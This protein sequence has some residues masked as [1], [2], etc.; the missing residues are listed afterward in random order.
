MSTVLVETITSPDPAIRNRSLRSLLEPMSTPQRLAECEALERFRRHRDNLYER[1]RACLFLYATHRFG[2]QEAPGITPA[3]AIPFDGYVDLLERRFEQAIGRFRAARE[4]DGA[5]AAIISALAEAYRHLAFQTLTDQVRRSVRSWRGNQWMFR[6]GHH[7]D[8]PVRVHP[9]L[10]R[11]EPGCILYPILTEQTPVRLDLS[12]SGWSDIFFLGM[13]HPEGARVLN[14]SVDLGVYGRD[15]HVRPPIETYVRVLEEP[16]LRLTSVDLEATKDVTALADLF[17]FGNDYLGLLKAGVIASGLIPP[18][19]EGS[20]QDLGAIL[21]QIVGPGLGLEVVTQVNDI[22]KGSRLAVSTNLLASLIALLM[23]AT[24]QTQR[25]EG[26]LEEYE[27]RLVASRAILGEWLGGSGGGWQ[28]SGGIWPGIKIIHGVVAAEGDPEFGV[29]RGCLLPQHQVFGPDRVSPQVRD[30]LAASMIV[31]HGGMAQDVGPILEMVTEKYLLRAGPEWEA[32]AELGRIFDG[33]VEALQ[34]GDVRGVASCTTRNWDGPLKTIIPQVTN[35][36]T[37]TLIRRAREQLGDD[38]WGF[39]MLG[40][41][42]GGGM[43]LFVAPHRQAAFRDELLDIMRHAKRDLD[44]ALPFAIDPVVYDFRINDYGSVASVRTGPAAIMPPRYYAVQVPALAHLPRA[45]VPLLRRADL[46]TFTSTG[47]DPAE[48]L[49]VLRVMVNHLFPAPGSAADAQA[50]AWQEEFRRIQRENGFDAVQ[51]E[52][53]RED[54]RRGRIGLARNRLAADTEIRDVEPGDVI[55]IQGGCADEAVRAGEDA[56][57][58]GEVAIVS[59]AAGVGSRWTRG[60]GVVKAVNPFVFI[61]GRHRSF[62]EIHLAKSRRASRRFGADMPHVFTT[63]FLTHQPIERHLAMHNRYGYAGPLSLSP[64]RSIATRLVPMVRDLR[65][66]WEELPQE[67]LD[68]Q[69][70]KV[71]DD[72]RAA[73]IAWARQR[74]EGS[75]YVD[76][77]PLQCFCPPGHWY[78]VPNLLRNG[79]LAQLLAARPNLKHLLVHNIDTLGADAD[80]GPLGV[81]V[82]SDNCLTFEVIGRRIDDRGGGLA[83]VNGRVR[84]LEGLAQPREAD[85]FRLR[86]YNSM[87]TWVNIDRLLALFGL[88]REALTGPEETIAERIRTAAAR[89]PTYVTIKEVKRRWGHGQE[90]VFPV[91]Q[92]EKLWSDMTSL[93]DVRCGFLVVPRR[94]GQQLKDVAQLDPWLNDGSLPY[95]RSL[96]DFD[97]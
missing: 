47:K 4:R 63:S 97:S 53:L 61:D 39:L 33:L 70:Q 32:R 69:K 37:E 51:H 17:N 66:L 38:F 62:L 11:R 79:V 9:R 91:S 89:L 43:A 40:G 72:V 52:Q 46:D 21:A 27:R 81:H 96:C 95:V 77:T 82:L 55:D 50:D 12:H 35:H 36:F 26:P 24:S 84:L 65:F 19:F 71:R 23:R 7:A 49:R 87:T 1:V 64:G 14:I 80:P 13:D 8:H 29:S 92:T 16:A 85:E 75:D 60:A 3:G 68:E 54:L 44:D 56:L 2:L 18:S 20:G 30:A 31:V 6:V 93:P 67:T 22:P 15:R 73:L 5:N 59:L 45:Q 76:N 10:R 28:D 83:R 86:Y 41:M 57:R 90:D 48:L 88:S 58:R 78:E 42:S 74:G 34:R 25:L 94:R